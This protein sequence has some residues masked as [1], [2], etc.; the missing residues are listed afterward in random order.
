[1]KFKETLTKMIM[2]EAFYF[3]ETCHDYDVSSAVKDHGRCNPATHTLPSH[4]V[5]THLE[6]EKI[7]KSKPRER[8]LV[9]TRSDKEHTAKA[10]PSQRP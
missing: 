8:P 2:H 4:N 7:A 5:S 6:T 10:K 1:M 9:A 3:R